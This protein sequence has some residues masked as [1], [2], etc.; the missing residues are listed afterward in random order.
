MDINTWRNIC[1]LAIFVGS[2]IAGLG[3]VGVWY[4]GRQSD[5]AKD[6]KS[7]IQRQ[8]LSQQLGD[9]KRG[10][11]LLQGGNEALLKRLEPFER[12]AQERFPSAPHDEAMEKL[13]KELA[14]VK[15]LATRDMPKPLQASVRDQVV[16]KLRELKNSPSVGLHFH[17][18]NLRNTEQLFTQLEEILRLGGIKH[19]V[20]TLTGMSIGLPA[21]AAYSVDSAPAS[22]TTAKALVVA[23]APFL[24]SP[25]RLNSVQNMPVGRVEISIAGQPDF[26]PDGSVTIR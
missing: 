7:E 24:G 10:N 9:L 25:K 4:F 1:Q 18:T 14:D 17:N 21:W 5:A 19:E 22:E 8:E 16:S 2:G 15:N 12:L 13:R 11:E 23:L 6:V 3:G 26:N 20:V